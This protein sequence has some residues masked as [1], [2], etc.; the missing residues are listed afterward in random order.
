M[1]CAKTCEKIITILCNIK[2]SQYQ[3]N[4]KISKMVKFRIIVVME[5]VVVT[6]ALHLC[7]VSL[8]PSPVLS[9]HS[10]LEQQQKTRNMKSNHKTNIQTAV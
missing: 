9:L 2:I 10:V 5:C 6:D 3:N 8:W 4:T 7:D 1:V